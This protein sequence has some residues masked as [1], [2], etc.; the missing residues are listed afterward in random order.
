MLPSTAST[1]HQTQ[2]DALDGS[3]EESKE[4]Q[5][6]K[7]SWESR[8]LGFPLQ[9]GKNQHWLRKPNTESS[10]RDHF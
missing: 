4:I 1:P 3:L 6:I 7:E 10:S 8:E 5:P 9:I 2:E